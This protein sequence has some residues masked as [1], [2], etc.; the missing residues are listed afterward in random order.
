[1]GF[2][3]KGLRL[4]ALIG[5]VLGGMGMI[6]NKAAAEEGDLIVLAAP[7]STSAYYQD[8]MPA[9]LEF[10]TGFSAAVTAP[11]KL[12]IL[13]DDDQYAVYKEAVGADRLVRAPV[14][15]IWTRDFGTVEPG[16][17]VMFRYTAAGQGGG[18][19]GQ[20]DADAVQEG[21]AGLLEQAGLA[22]R[23]TD[24]LNDG[25]NYVDNA[26]GAGQRRA[27]L[28]R[29]FLRD[30]RLSEQKARNQLLERMGLTAVAFIEADE[31]GGLEHADGVVAFVEPDSLVIN[32][33]KDDPDYASALRQDLERQLP[34]VAI[35]E[36]VN[37]YSGD[38][39]IDE[40]FGSA[41]GLYTNM[42]VTPHR[43]YVP[44]FGIPEDQEAL[45]TLARLTN[46]EIIP[47]RSD[48]I[49]FMGGGVRCMSWQLRGEPAAQFLAW[50]QAQGGR[51]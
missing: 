22:F 5:A 43:L 2:P 18:R 3:N 33:Y 41:C 34:G 4:G 45:E 6:E 49:C 11:D 51:P 39:I 26:S 8:V 36:I 35:H 32:H 46:K 9:I 13:V 17:P 15:D 37:A 31:Q 27:V 14:E 44:Q 30:N 29:K 12:L 48:Q 23:E 24:L 10:H 21:L 1:M 7:P 25:G 42:M 38:G 20:Q 40:R 19:K 28:S 50:A 47:V 16:E